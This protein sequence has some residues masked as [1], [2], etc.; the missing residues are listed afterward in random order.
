MH[1]FKM[2]NMSVYTNAIVF[3]NGLDGLD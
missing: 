1:Q 2:L 3:A